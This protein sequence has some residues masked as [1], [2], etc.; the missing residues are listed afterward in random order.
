MKKVFLYFLL[1]ITTVCTTSCGENND[2]SSSKNVESDIKLDNTSLSLNYGES[3]S[4]SILSDNS[5]GC[6]ITVDNDY[7]ASCSKSGNTINVVSK[8]VG[9]TYAKV[10]NGNKS[11]ILHISV[12]STSQNVSGNPI[13]MFGE[14][15]NEVCDSLG[16]IS[17]NNG[18]TNYKE[19][20]IIKYS[21][22]N[23]DGYYFDYIYY[24]YISDKG[25]MGNLKAICVYVSSSYGS[26]DY[27]KYQILMAQKYDFVS[28]TQVK[29]GLSNNLYKYGIN[30]WVRSCEQY[31]SAHYQIMINI[32]DDVNALSSLFSE[33]GYPR[34]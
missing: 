15:Y 30:T 2:D 32:S 1:A 28:S 13:M 24:F 23:S 6:Q 17:K 27:S 8:H 22:K 26:I 31:S 21:E 12:K 34:Y 5:E 10:T 9:D 18:I 29:Y 4:I 16:K 19:S 14:S 20:D 3:G 7:I 11:I 25:K 33:N